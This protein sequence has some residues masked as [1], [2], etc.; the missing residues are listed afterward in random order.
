MQEIKK[1]LFQNNSIRQTVAKNTFWAAFGTTITKILRITLII[2]IARVLGADNYGV[3]TYALSIV[4][5]FTIFSD[6][7]LTSILTREL[8]K[9]NQD[10]NNYLATAFLVKIGF[11]ISTIVLIIIFGPLITKFNSAKP[12]LVILALTTILESLRNFFFAITRSENQMEKEAALNIAIEVIISLGIIFIFFRQPSLQILARTYFIGNL[13]GL[14]VTLFFFKPYLNQIINNIKFNL[15]KPI[16]Q[17]AWPFALMGV[18]GVFMSNIDSIIIGL[19]NNTHTL[20]L[21]AVAQRPISFLYILPGFLSVSIFPIINRFS[22][23]NENTKIATTISKSTLLSLAIALPITLGGIIVANALINIMFGSQ[24]LGSVCTFQI[25]LITLIFVFPGSILSD[26]LLAED[27]RRAL[28][29][30]SFWTAATNV[31]LDLILIPKFGIIGSAIATVVAQMILTI[32]YYLIIKKTTDLKIVTETKK[33]ILSAIIM[34]AITFLLLKLSLPLI[35]IIIIS[36]IIYILNLFIL[37][38]KII[39]EIFKSFKSTSKA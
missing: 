17:A 6:I 27:R 26:L 35:L 38:E 30:S 12:L 24:Y 7:G 11:L 1:F 22:K 13:I 4:G 10:K 18:F 37:K 34:S 14:I 9:R 36:A 28:I 2:F 23:N 31:I 29:W 16:L 25:L 3:F 19:F 32:I 20:G 33:I 5:V 15:I 8:T 39:E 21:Y